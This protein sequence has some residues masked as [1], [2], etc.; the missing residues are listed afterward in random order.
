MK[1]GIVV[2]AC[3][4]CPARL[5]AGASREAFARQ[6]EEKGWR[7]VRGAGG[8]Q[9]QIVCPNCAKKVEPKDLIEPRHAG[10]TT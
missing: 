3:A 4:R 7:M 8:P 9:R 10:A 6:L 1:G 2:I 5:A